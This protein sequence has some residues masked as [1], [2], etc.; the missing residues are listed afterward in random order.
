MVLQ[1]SVVDYLKGTWGGGG[2][3]SVRDTR[4]QRPRSHIR[5]FE[6]YFETAASIYMRGTGGSLRCIGVNNLPCENSTLTFIGGAIICLWWRISSYRDRPRTWV[7]VRTA[8]GT[9]CVRRFQA[10]FRGSS[11]AAG[12]KS[13]WAGRGLSGRLRHGWTRRETEDGVRVG[14]SGSGDGAGSSDGIYLDC[15]VASTTTQS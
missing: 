2:R 14:T 10:M 13:N 4:W 8:V 6:G 7:A 1:I 12:G 3:G 15:S 11:T 9:S 5:E